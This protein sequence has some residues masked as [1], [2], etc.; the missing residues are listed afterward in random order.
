MAEATKRGKEKIK[1]TLKNSSEWLH[2][3]MNVKLCIYVGICKQKLNKFYI[4][5]KY[6]F[7]R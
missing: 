5:L 6:E 7:L 3:F 2:L 1:I 4:C